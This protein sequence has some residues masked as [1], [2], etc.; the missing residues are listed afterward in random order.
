MRGF[1]HCLSLYTQATFAQFVQQMNQYDY[2]QVNVR[3]Y[4]RAA[5]ASVIELTIDDHG[6]I[7]IPLDTLK[8][9]KLDKNVKIVGINDHIEIWG[10]QVWE[11]Y[12]SEAA[13]Q[14][15]SHAA[16]LNKK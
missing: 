7:Q 12:H 3:Q 11:S 16:N 4:L 14:F 6:R 8:V 2:N 5:L 9:F 1:E 10:A 13:K 15:E